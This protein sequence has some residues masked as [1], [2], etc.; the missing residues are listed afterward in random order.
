VFGGRFI[1]G[2]SD[3]GGGEAGRQD[4]DGVASAAAG[5]GR[6][7]CKVGEDGARDQEEVS[8]GACAR[9]KRP[10]VEL[11]IEDDEKE[12]EVEDGRPNT[13]RAVPSFSVAIYEMSKDLRVP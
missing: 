6:A 12:H 13:P 10:S 5:D 8:G 4:G 9:R 7:V 11:V 1:T 2:M 3:G